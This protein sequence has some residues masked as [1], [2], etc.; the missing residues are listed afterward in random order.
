MG[1]VREVKVSSGDHVRNGQ[2]L[3]VI[4]SRDLDVALQQAK[5]V[6]QEAHSGIAEAENGIVAAKAQLGLAQATFHRM[7]D[8]FEKK[9]I[10]NQEAHARLQTAEAA[11]QMAVSRRAQL[12]AK[13]AQAKQGVESASVMRTYGEIRAPFSGIITE[14]RVEPGQMATPG[15]PLLTIEHAGG[16]RLE[17]AVEESLL[18]AVRIGQSVSVVLDAFGETVSGR[19]SE[20]VPAVD[21]SSRAFVVKVN[22]PA[23]PN[24]R[25]GLFGRLRISRGS[26]PA[27]AVPETAVSQRGDIR[28]VFVVEESLAWSRMVTTGDRRDGRVE[29]L[30]GLQDGDRIVYPRP[31]GLRDGARVEVRR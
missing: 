4:D 23:A 21:P 5:A 2:L 17:S 3:V 11:H 7:Q 20:I 19:V 6:E 27:M 9:S 28:T 26:H 16:Y 31:A 25:S 24:I 15:T 8:L 29:I 14:K 18:G 30:S 10:S 22:L 12:D 1:Y 13:I